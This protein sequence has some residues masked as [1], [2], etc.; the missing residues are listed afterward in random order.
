MLIGWAAPRGSW[1]GVVVV[2]CASV[3]VWR[4]VYIGLMVVM[5]D[6]LITLA[7]VLQS[8]CLRG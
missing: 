2:G 5:L 6:E 3:L 7:C 8:I 4:H 1:V